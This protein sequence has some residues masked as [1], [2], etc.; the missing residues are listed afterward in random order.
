MTVEPMTKAMQIIDQLKDKRLVYARAVLSL[1]EAERR[2]ALVIA[3]IEMDAI[4]R[5]GGEKAL[6]SNQAARDREL[7]FVVESAKDYT[8][9]LDER[10]M[11]YLAKAEAS[12]KVKALEEELKVILAFG[13]KENDA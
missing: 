5:V 6:G 1:A 13:G 9:A 7:L 8:Y 3:N 2:L 10:S 12:A 11:A 4:R